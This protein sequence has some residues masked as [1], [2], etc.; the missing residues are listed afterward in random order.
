MTAI[1]SIFKAYDIRGIYPR[2]LDEDGA[3]AIGRAFAA[4]I[5]KGESDTRIR[6]AVGGDM[7]LSTPTLKERLI[8]GLLESGI[9]VDDLGLVSTPTFYFAVSHGGYSGGVQVSA[10]HNP[11]EWNGFKLVRERAVPISMD[12]GIAAIR[13]MIASEKLASAVV[14]SER[15]VLSISDSV[16]D[17]QIAVQMK[18]AGE[19]PIKRFKIAIDTANGMAAPEMQALF[20]KVPADIHWIN[21]EL[22]GTFPAHPADPLVEAN[23]QEIR[24]E[25]V[26]HGCDLGIATDGDGDRYFFFDEKGDAVPL[27]ILRGIL[28]QI[29]LAAHPGSTVAYD[30]RPGRITRDLIDAVGGKSIVTPVGHSLIK[31]QML[32]SDAVFGGESSG[33]FF[34]KLPYGTFEAPLVL[35]IKFLQYLTAQNKPLSEI[36][37]PY[38]VYFNSGEI[39]TRLASRE[40]GLAKI[41]E[42]KQAYGD[43]QISE[44]DGLFV[45]FPDYWFG[46]RLSNTE[47]L[48]RLIVEARTKEIL[49]AKK[50]EILSRI[51][52]SPETLALVH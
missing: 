7:R 15:G 24:R 43:G 28:S 16:L 42:I 51:K 1:P 47:P 23:T 45:E 27:E 12:S 4:E 32:A 37:A 40:E 30:I 49:E 31:A 20:S 13:D 41:E 21:T 44:I 48:L 36:I 10:S 34:Y 50:D 52:K 35:V 29:E 38:R 17:N 3:Y 14:Q 18:D 9:D 6:V 46:I 2:E 39:N 22:D 33:H 26:A 5:R 8:E 11:K 25:L 19:A